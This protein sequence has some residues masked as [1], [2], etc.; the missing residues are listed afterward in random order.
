MKTIYFPT[1]TAIFILSLTNG[2]QAQKN[3][4]QIID[5]LL[6]NGGYHLHFA[7]IPGKGMPI[8]FETGD[9]D[10][11]TIWN[12]IAQPIADITGAP[13]ITY[14]R[15]GFGKSTIDPERKGIEDEIKGLETA[16]M[17]LGY[18]KE[19]M[20]VS[21]SIG[22]F[23]NT[24]FASRNAER[25]KGIVFID[26]RVVCNL[27]DD[28]LKE[29]DLNPS[30][31]EIV[32][33]MKT[34]SLLPANIPIVD[35]TSEQ[36]VIRD[37]SWKTL[38]DVFVSES[39]NR[40]GILAYKT[41]H[42]IFLDNSRL[43]I[44]AIVSLYSDLQKPEDK[45]RILEKAYAYELTSANDDYRKKIEYQYSDNDLIEWS[46][47]LLLKNSMA[48]SL[49][50]LKLNVS[51]YPESIAAC[52]ALAEAYLKTGNKELA[53]LYYK[54]SLELNP[55]NRNTQLIMDQISRIIEVPDSSLMS[56]VGEYE[57]NG[58]P[59]S[60]TK[61]NNNLILNFNNTQSVAYF[62]SNIDF[63][64]VEYRNEFKLTKDSDG[65]VL[66]FLFRG[67]KAMKVK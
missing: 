15:Q 54:R 41:S 61:E 63:F 29:M 31:L 38:H 47:S 51:L 4:G 39:P 24:V 20:L 53:S 40:K 58:V 67:M 2:I 12:G 14:D 48:N 8:L 46:K 23:Y 34:L 62:T 28:K 52:D 7:I 45:V 10:N 3:N 44:D 6:D 18:A 60:I 27:T 66:G 13:I 16:L 43:T 1:I 42:Y 55:D 26:A 64:I 32:K 11:A 57:L 56:Y 33:T 17:K 21:H 5:T 50:I 35:I 9:R 30:Q 36:N 22:G 59:V 65:K 19:I 37:N 25:V 49:E